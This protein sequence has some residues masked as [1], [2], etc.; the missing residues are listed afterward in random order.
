MPLQSTLHALPAEAASGGQHYSPLPHVGNLIP[1]LR[2]T[3]ERDKKQEV[4]I[5]T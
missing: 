5:T 4:C 2:G 1:E 3:V